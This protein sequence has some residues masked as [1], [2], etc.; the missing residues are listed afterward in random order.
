M[1]LIA[2]KMGISPII[3]IWEASEIGLRHASRRSHWARGAIFHV[4][5]R[6]ICGSWT[7]SQ[8]S[9]GLIPFDLPLLL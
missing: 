3:V 2:R 6:L 1:I 5:K 4:L 9:I 7:T 8:K